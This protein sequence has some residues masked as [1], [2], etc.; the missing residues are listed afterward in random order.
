MQT[1]RHT[2]EY[3][4]RSQLY[5]DVRLSSPPPHPHIEKI[6]A[7]T[8]TKTQQQQQQ[9]K[10]QKKKHTFSSW[11]FILFLLIADTHLYTILLLTPS[12]FTPC[13]FLS[14][15]HHFSQSHMQHTTHTHTKQKERF[16]TKQPSC[17]RKK[18][19]LV[20]IAVD[21]S[22]GC[23]KV[24]LFFPLFLC[25]HA[26]PAR[27]LCS[28]THTAHVYIIYNQSPSVSMSSSSLPPPMYLLTSHRRDSHPFPLSV[29]LRSCSPM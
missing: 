24:S 9:H 11:L 27:F 13:A 28:K 10:P 2:P 18:V 20:P 3:S 21:S 15:P 26:L 16:L 14:S 12:P 8:L 4:Q 23:M 6:N 1:H 7:N 17:L 22:I 19:P 5:I 29:S 25:L